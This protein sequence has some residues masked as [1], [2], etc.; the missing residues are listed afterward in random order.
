MVYT[1]NGGGI[2]YIAIEIAFQETTNS[3]IERKARL[4]SQLYDRFKE[5]QYFL[6]YVTDG[7]GYF[8]R[9]S[10]LKEIIC[11]SHICVT[12]KKNELNRLCKFIESI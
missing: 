8:S 10:A 4:A 11:N 12:F 6:C 2:K 7:A 1:K 9:E 3:V 5:L